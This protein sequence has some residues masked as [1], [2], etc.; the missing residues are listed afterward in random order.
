MTFGHMTLMALASVSHDV[1]GIN[2]GTTALLRSR[3]LNE[4]QH[5]VL[6]I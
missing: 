4:I 6:V 2:S 5:D 1:D 3:Q